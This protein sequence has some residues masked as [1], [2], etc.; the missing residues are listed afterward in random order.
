MIHANGVGELSTLGVQ[1]CAFFAPAASGALS[2][3]FVLEILATLV[4]I[5]HTTSGIFVF[6]QD[7]QKQWI[8]AGEAL[9]GSRT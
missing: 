6:V 4:A 2:S 3:V 5:R 9:A 1:K 7:V 8:S